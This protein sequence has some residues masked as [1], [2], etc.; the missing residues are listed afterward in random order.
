M[1]SVE[2][3]QDGPS[4]VSPEEWALKKT[5]SPGGIFRQLW[6]DTTRITVFGG[7]AGTG[8]SRFIMEKAH[9]ACLEYP[10]I[11]VLFVRKTRESLAQSVMVT[12]EERVVPEA[13]KFFGDQSREHRTGYRYPPRLNRYT[14]IVG[15]S[16]IILQGMQ[17]SGK[18]NIARVM[19]TEYD[20]ICA[21]ELI[22][23]DQADVLKLCTR[24][25]NFKRRVQQFLGDSNP[26]PPDHWII[27]MDA[28]QQLKL[29]HT[30]HKDNPYLWDEKKQDWTF[31][32]ADYIGN[33]LA[34]MPEGLEKERLYYG[35]WV[36]AEG[37]VYD[38]F[39]P[40]F[41]YIDQMPEGWH[42]WRKIRAIDFGYQNPFVC[43]WFAIDYDGRMYMYRELYMS[44]RTVQVH[45]P[46]ITKLSQGEEFE[47]TVADHDAG[48]RA[49]LREL[50]IETQ[51]A[52]KDI[53]VG[54]Q[55]VKERLKIQGDGK[56]RLYFLKNCLVERDEDL[57]LKKDPVCLKDEFGKYVY[58]K[59]SGGKVVKENPVDKD[60]HGADA[61]R[62]AVMCIDKHFG[63]IEKLAEA[64]A[65]VEKETQAKVEAQEEWLNPEN[66]ALWSEIDD[67]EDWV[68]PRDFAERYN[69]W[70]FR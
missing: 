41:H 29:V 39:D 4:H 70:R 58:P 17:Q 37:V 9:A 14:G 54:I 1:S 3:D 19:S 18:E 62:Y 10:G 21:F 59:D 57:W 30:T 25:R 53:G 13:N 7:P 66:P 11:R 5:Y 36:R 16:E 68:D 50:D 55:A 61:C 38:E 27:R 42:S 47:T 43:L 22:E 48:E 23:F 67:G 33:N 35:R 31:E 24:L 49:T 44:G 63:P 34:K 65:R 6:S 69:P 26:G 56:A 8:K 20:M 52:R 32:G 46:Q 12:F 28:E 45:A 40:S 15:T 64:K 2:L 51:S 60:N